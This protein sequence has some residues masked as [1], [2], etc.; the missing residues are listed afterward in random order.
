MR[1][2]KQPTT[3]A[4]DMFQNLRLEIMLKVFEFHE[5]KYLTTGMKARLSTRFR[6]LNR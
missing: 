1:Q 6:F 4:L 2:P 3:R 5:E